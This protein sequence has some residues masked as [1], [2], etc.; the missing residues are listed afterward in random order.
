MNGK[1]YKHHFKKPNK[2]YIGQ[3]IHKI[4]RRLYTHLREAK[5]RH[6]FDNCK[7]K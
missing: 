2:S 5:K 3:T 1:I 4:E 7:Y 6:H